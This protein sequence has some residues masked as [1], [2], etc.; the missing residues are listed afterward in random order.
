MIIPVYNEERTIG[1]C[2]E[3]LKRQSYKDTEIIIID[4]GS[5]DN[6]KLKAQSSK[7]QFKTRN[8]R[9]LEQKHGGAG[10]ARN[11]GARHARGEILVF[12]DADMTFTK[13][14][15]E[16]LVKPIVEGK[17]IGTYS[18]DEKL[19]NKTDPWA[20]CWNLNFSGRSSEVTTSTEETTARR[21]YHLVKNLLESIE[22]WIAPIS[23]R[24]IT[25][26]TVGGSHLPYRAILKSFFDSV[27]GFTIS[28]G[29]TDDWTL[30]E[31]LNRLPTP[32]SAEYYHRSPST[33]SE[34]W[35][36]A[37]WIGKDELKTGNTV[38]QL[39]SL[40]VHNPLSA[41]ILCVTGAIRYRNARFFLFRLLYSTAISVS[42][43]ES[44]VR[45]S[46]AK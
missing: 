31:K 6:S 42:V 12:V 5:T 35:R 29:Y 4:D 40:A 28:P 17:T 11:L 32:V 14:F 18:T 30:A 36:Q 22:K 20:V 21:F 2:L 39:K 13:D 37:R 23:H 1:E 26:L 8:F 3:S 44:F 41:F 25:A 19:L 34:V 46:R 7:L 27:G 16:K 45:R 33:I 38:R 10:K 15:I 43:L 24:K 9:I